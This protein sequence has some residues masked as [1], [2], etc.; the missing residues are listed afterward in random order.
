MKIQYFFSAILIPIIAHSSLFGQCLELDNISTLS[1]QSYFYYNPN[2]INISPN[3]GDVFHQ[4]GNGIV[5][6]GSEVIHIKAL[7]NSK[8][9]HMV[10]VNNGSG[11]GHLVSTST[12]PVIITPPTQ[13]RKTFKKLELSLSLPELND[14]IKTF[15]DNETGEYKPGTTRYEQKCN[16]DVILNPYDPD[17]INIVAEFSRPGSPFITKRYAFYYIPYTLDGQLGCACPGWDNG[18][19]NDEKY[20]KDWKQAENE[21]EWRI[22]YAPDAIS[23]EWAC[24]IRVFVKGKIYKQAE[25]IFEVNVDSGDKGFVVIDNNKPYF[26]YNT[27][28][29][30]FFPI[31]GNFIPSRGSDQYPDCCRTLNQD[32]KYH[33]KIFTYANDQFDKYLSTMCSFDSDGNNIGG[34]CV[35]IFLADAGLSVEREKLNNYSSRQIEMGVL[36]YYLDQ[37]DALGV[38]MILGLNYN[39]DYEPNIEYDNNFSFTQRWGWNPYNNDVYNKLNDVSYNQASNK[40]LKGIEQIP[41]KHDAVTDYRQFFTN[42]KAKEIYKKQLRYIHSRWGYSPHLFSYELLTEIDILAKETTDYKVQSYHTDK[43]WNTKRYQSETIMFHNDVCDWIDEM[44]GY[45][46]VDMACKQLTTA[47]YGEFT[48]CRKVDATPEGFLKNYMLLWEK[49]NIDFI[50]GHA[51]NSRETVQHLRYQELCKCFQTDVIKPVFLGEYDYDGVYSG[52]FMCNDINWHNSNWGLLLSGFCGGTIWDNRAA[53]PEY[54]LHQ[55]Q[56]EVASYETETNILYIGDFEKNYKGLRNFAELV[57]SSSIDGYSNKFTYSKLNQTDIRTHGPHEVAYLISNSSDRAYGWIRNRSSVFQNYSNIC[58]NKTPYLDYSESI[59]NPT[60]KLYGDAK[61]VRNV[62]KETKNISESKGLV[63]TI[64][65]P[66]VFNT[67]FQEGN[68]QSLNK[69]DDNYLEYFPWKHVDE[70]DPKPVGGELYLLNNP[71]PEVDFYTSSSPLNHSGPG[72]V[73]TSDWYIFLE[74]LNSN[75]VYNV[76]WY[77]TRGNQAGTLAA[78]FN[79]SIFNTGTFVGDKFKIKVPPTIATAVQNPYPGDWAFSINCISPIDSQLKTSVSNIIS[80]DLVNIMVTPIPTTSFLNIS[81]LS[82]KEFNISIFSSQSNLVKNYG[83][84]S[85]RQMV[86]N[87]SDLS[88][89]IYFLKFSNADEFRIIKVIKL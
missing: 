81:S 53:F 64:N 3:V 34:N 23:K 48:Y 10:M 4:I 7:N 61:I 38:Y 27:D 37:I 63:L 47:S 41:G 15:L 82:E 54:G 60:L 44:A 19:M 74:G 84:C 22:R 58:Y 52:A 46:K 66:Q 25:V 70:I 62:R 6:Y 80:N 87:I 78:D 40:P 50:S 14:R 85:I 88:S 30:P 9:F 20:K 31:G 65:A 76:T 42:S 35:R 73:E 36:D 59:T 39:A 21:Y 56:P 1:E 12:I 57:L 32:H 69:G 89:G 24:K 77:W 8:S 51:Y 16:E 13:D 72:G 71:F 28:D 79:T 5:E 55:T 43:Y 29:T 45:L 11:Y 75:K 67:M 2:C 26:K 68:K 18:T 83:L 49:P 17:H 86:L 33:E